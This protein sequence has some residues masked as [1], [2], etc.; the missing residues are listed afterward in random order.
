VECRDAL[1]QRFRAVVMGAAA[2]LTRGGDL[3]AAVSLLDRLLRDNPDDEPVQRLLSR[4]QADAGPARDAP[5]PAAHRRPTRQ[6]ADPTSGPQVQARPPTMLATSAS[7]PSVK[8]WLPHIEPLS[9]QNGEIRAARVGPGGEALWLSARWSRPEFCLYRLAMAPGR[10]MPTEQTIAETSVELFACS[11]QGELALGRRARFYNSFNL[12]ATLA[13]LPASGGSPIDLLE[14]VHCADWQPAQPAKPVRATPSAGAGSPAPAASQAWT[15][16]AIVREVSGRTQLEFPIGTVRF[17][18]GGWLS[19][20]RFSPDGQ[21]LAFIEHPI[22]MDDEGSVKLIDLRRPGAPVRTLTPNCL[23][24]RGLAWVGEHI[25]FTASRKGPNRALHRVDLNG[26][27][28]MMY[29]GL[30]SLTLHDA[31]PGG[32]GDVRS[33]NMRLVVTA[34]RFSFGICARHARDLQEHDISWHERTVPRELSDD[35]EWLLM[36]DGGLVGRHPFL[37]YLR[38]LDG[39]GTRLVAPG[40]P[41]AMSRDLRH[42][43]LR[44]P[45]QPSALSLLNLKTG[46]LRALE[47]YATQGLVHTEFVSFFPDG[48]RIAFAA[49]D[50]QGHSRVYLQAL[51]GGPPSCFTPNETGVRMYNNRAVSPLGDRII[52]KRADDLL[53][54]YDVANGAALRAL[55]LGPEFHLT[56]WSTDGQHVYVRRWGEPISTVFRHRLI[57]GQQHEWLILS[58]A[59]PEGVQLIS[60]VRLTPDGRSYAYGYIRKTS[61]LFAFEGPP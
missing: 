45:S 54:L 20:L 35:G 2:A 5:P 49:S 53:W 25:W 39:S 3:A 21:R 58:P 46:Q 23:S 57:D 4:I 37:A 50:G 48:R 30:G 44:I 32:V 17:E 11:D 31:V 27:E 33:D 22:T 9:F 28:Q 43:I 36:E 47:N 26:V 6:V 61:D 41:L 52:L 42:V 10:S 16:L 1:Q 15:R 38:R 51:A 19:S 55:P 13:V 29:Q 59:A 34:E 56:G 60:S 8:A 24:L 18:T 12:A 40:V 7:V 14:D